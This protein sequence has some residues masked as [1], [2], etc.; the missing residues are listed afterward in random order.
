MTP[1]LGSTHHTRE[2]VERCCLTR[3][4]LGAVEVQVRG[5]QRAVPV[6]GVGTPNL[7]S[8]R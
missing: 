8:I 3:T 1:L 7:E 2:H 5:M 6:P 4:Q